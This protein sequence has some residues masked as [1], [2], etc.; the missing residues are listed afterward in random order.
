MDGAQRQHD[1]M[2]TIM[3][4][5]GVLAERA[6]VQGN[7]D[8][9]ERERREKEREEERALRERREKE[10]EEERALRERREK[11][12]EEERAL[13]ERRE[14]ELAEKQDRR[15]AMLLDRFE[16][17]SERLSSVST[18]ASNAAASNASRGTAS[19]LLFSSP[20]VRIVGSSGTSG[21]STVSSIGPSASQ[22]S[23]SSSGVSGAGNPAFNQL[24]SGAGNPVF[25]QLNGFARQQQ[26]AVSAVG[27]QAGNAVAP[28]VNVNAAFNPAFLL[29]AAALT[30]PK[31]NR[32]DKPAIVQFDEQLQ[33][34]NREVGLEFARTPQSLIL[35]RETQVVCAKHHITLQQWQAL[36][37]DEAMGLLYRMHEVTNT[38]QY[39]KWKKSLPIMDAAGDFAALLS[40][41]TAFENAVLSIGVQYRHASEKVLTVFSLSNL[42]PDNFREHVRDLRPANYDNAKEIAGAT[43][44]DFEWTPVTF[45]GDSI[46]KTKVQFE[47]SVSLKEGLVPR[48]QRDLSNVECHKCKKKGHYANKCTQG[49]PPVQGKPFPRKIQQLVAYPAEG[50]KSELVLTDNEDAS[51]DV[52]MN[53]EES[54][55]AEEG[56][57]V[58]YESA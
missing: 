47:P 51:D 35:A 41:I 4:S 10:L 3:R 26:P 14:K 28:A 17:L 6:V 30:L 27:A 44:G 18:A 11:E 50:D 19:S 57:D 21:S 48:V 58:E 16:E 13:R 53:E 5:L 40:Y 38:Q 32:L 8:D 37:A 54:S 23:S 25:N 7:P 36:S 15:D 1:M 39:K 45:V 43:I 29:R 46:V 9:Q 55:A 52:D 20:V 24:N 31:I 2:E 56:G 34:Y 12:R 42:R 33:T 22:V 49:T